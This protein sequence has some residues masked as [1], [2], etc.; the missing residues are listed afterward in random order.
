MAQALQ[1]LPISVEEYLEGEEISEIKHEYIAG[2][3]YAMSGGTVNHSTVAVNFVRRAANQLAGKPCRAFN[4]DMKVRVDLGTDWAFY[5]PD[6]S[7]VCTPIGGKAH[8]TDAPAVILE[9][10]SDSTRHYDEL[11]KMRDY[12]TIPSL[13]AYVL[14]EADFE[15]ITI[16][17]RLGEEFRIEIITDTAATLQLP[18]VGI[19]IPIIDLYEDVDTG[20]N[21]H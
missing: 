17:R 21:A 5:Y 1:K 7:I 15:K 6:A 9:V 16:Y 18:D 4:S 10:L 11:R 14:A 3:V 12:L 13:Q 2:R 20:E 19:A 8:F